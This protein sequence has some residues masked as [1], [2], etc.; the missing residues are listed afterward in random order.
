MKQKKSTKTIGE[1]DYY[2]LAKQIQ[3]NLFDINAVPLSVLCAIEDSNLNKSSNLVIHKEVFKF[4]QKLLKLIMNFNKKIN[5]DIDVLDTSIKTCQCYKIYSQV[6][7]K[8][9]DK[10]LQI[11]MFKEVFP[12]CD[13]D[14]LKRLAKSKKEIA[15]GNS[16]GKNQGPKG[17]AIQAV[18]DCL[19]LAPNTVTNRLNKFN[20]NLYFDYS[21]RVKY[22]FPNIIKKLILSINPNLKK[23][24]INKILKILYLKDNSLN[25]HL[26]KSEL[27]K[28]I[29][30]LKKK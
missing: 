8:Q 13:K 4:N 5:K 26:K 15:E 19:N 25:F 16:E 1:I 30:V 18:S 23:S 11:K 9:L 6:S 10:E 20:E 22:D 12:G 3:R 27:L 21:L 14:I 28:S 2:K 24:Q 17:A 7:K 29:E